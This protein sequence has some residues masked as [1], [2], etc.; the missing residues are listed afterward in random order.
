MENN[1]K[2]FYHFFDIETP[3]INLKPEN[4]P[5]RDDLPTI[6]EIKKALRNIN[7]RDKALILL[8]LSSGMAENEVRELKT[9]NFIEA[10]GIPK[11]TPLDELRSTIKENPICTFITTKNRNG[12][13]CSCLFNKRTSGRMLFWKIIFSIS[14]SG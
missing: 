1:I 10:I 7:T 12:Y 2:T 6:D 4:P 9:K 3:K 11:N 13:V 8:H 5:R 14:S